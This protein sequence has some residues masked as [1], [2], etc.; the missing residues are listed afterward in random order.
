MTIEV[1]ILETGNPY[2]PPPSPPNSLRNLE[3]C[4]YR[5]Q[6]TA[7][8]SSTYPSIPSCA[9]HPR[10]VL[11]LPGHPSTRQPKHRT[12]DST[13]S[14]SRSAQPPSKH[15]TARAKHAQCVTQVRTPAP[16]PLH[17][18][19]PQLKM[20]TPKT[21]RPKSKNPNHKRTSI[22]PPATPQI[23]SRTNKATGALK[24]T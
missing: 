23:P 9:R 12:P 24:S 8:L 21:K 2:L 6:S 22:S 17:P 3:P 18:Q 20:Q 15:R 5:A 7:P 4:K 13:A 14:S 10:L 16:Q 19:T 1:S 11:L